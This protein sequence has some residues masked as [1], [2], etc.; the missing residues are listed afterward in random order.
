M[1]NTLYVEVVRT[2]KRKA[3]LR[4][5]EQMEQLDSGQKRARQE[6]LERTTPNVT[7]LAIT[8]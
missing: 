4:K 8:V 3:G 7:L 2:E 5:A 6:E 1:G